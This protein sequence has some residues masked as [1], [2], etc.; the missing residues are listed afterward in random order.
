MGPAIGIPQC[1]DDRGRWRAGREYHYI[2]AAY[3]RAVAAAGG[4][5]VYLP[6]DADA[7]A[8]VGR[9][10]GLLIPGGDDF[11]PP[12]PY[13]DDVAFDPV[14][15]RQLAFDRALL[16]EALAGGLPVFAI[17]YGAQL[18]ALHHG[19][20][21][22]YHL[23]ADVPEAGEHQLPE[24]TGRHGLR[25]EEHS[26]LAR[27]LGGPPESVNSLHHQGIA[28]PG[29]GLRACAWADDGVIEAIEADA[30]GFCVGVQWH[31]E[32]MDEPQQA[33][34]FSAFVAA[35]AERARG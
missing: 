15:G 11:L 6:M 12:T 5:P 18:L 27:A 33:A 32:K 3:A 34:V 21:L 13:E 25:V 16:G 35:C 9:I 30:A 19:G 10:D 2:D 1:L 8:L 28:E 26:V 29:A 17:C 20:R 23:P 22:H 24:A 14:P 31:P 7:N 4:V